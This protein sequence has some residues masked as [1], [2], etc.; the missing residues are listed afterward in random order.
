MDKMT[1]RNFAE[2]YNL[3]LQRDPND[4]TDIIPGREG[5]SH[6]FEYDDQLLG[7]LILPYVHN[8]DATAHRWK[9]ARAAFTAAGMVIRQNGDCEGTASFDPANPEQAKLAMRYARIKPKRRLS[10]EH[11]ASLAAASQASRYNGS[12]TVLSGELMS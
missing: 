11:R 5:Q 1:I 7:V 8:P 10:P 3:K 9:A 6:I 2:Q 4:G 12:G